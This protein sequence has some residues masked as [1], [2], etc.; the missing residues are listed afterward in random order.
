MLRGTKK[1]FPNDYEKFK[2]YSLEAAEEENLPIAFQLD[3]LDDFSFNDFQDMFY[4]FTCDT[5]LEITGTIF[6]CNDC[7]K[8]H[9]LVEVNYPYSEEESILQ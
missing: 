9:L 1:L 6:T 4:E 3:N 2:T 5:G 7:G 8:L